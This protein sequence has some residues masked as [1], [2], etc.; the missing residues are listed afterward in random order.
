MEWLITIDQ[1]LF[2]FINQAGQNWLFDLLM[3]TIRNKLTWVPLY[4]L[5]L[6]VIA[7]KHKYRTFVFLIVIAI[8][9]LLSDQISSE[10]IKKTVERL[11]PCRDS[12]LD[13]VRTLVHCGGGF[14]F[15][16]S[17]ATNHFA[18]AMQ[19]FLLFR[20][21][22][23]SYAFIALFAWATLICY[24][25]V[26]VG[27]HFPLDVIAGGCLGCIIAWLVYQ[28]YSLSNWTIAVRLKI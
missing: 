22:W 23:S 20:K 26:Y 11:R 14:S 3:P 27:V 1:Q 9:I 4:I 24:G 10:L 15:T 25:Q 7:K 6:V 8:T 13:G 21:E 12:S 2:Y 17:H 16:S 18:V 28:L 19:L 5:L